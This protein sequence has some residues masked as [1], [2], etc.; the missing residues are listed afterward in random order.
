[1]KKLFI[2]NTASFK[3]E[4]FIPI[5]DPVGMYCCGPTVYNYAHI[6]N[7]RTYIFEDVL[8][9]VLLFLGYKVKHVINITDVGHLT[10]DADIGEDKMEKG[11]SREGKTVWEIAKYYTDAFKQNIK[12]LNILEPDIWP[13]ATDHIED[14]IN[15]IKIL[16]QKGYTYKTGDGIYFDTSK[17]PRYAEFAKL[18]V[19]NLEAGS[20]VDMGEK[21]NVTDFAL[22]KFSPKDKKR[23]M[24]WNSPWGIGF[25]GWHIECSSMSLKYLKQPIDIH[26]G[27]MDHIR[28]HHTNE[29][30][31]AEAATQE[32]FVKYW[33]HGEFLVL[34][35]GKM[36]KSSGNFITL[37]LLKEKGILPLSY[38][39]FCYSAHYRSPLIF[40]FEAVNAAQ[41][42]YINLKKAIKFYTNKP[43]QDNQISNENVEKMLSSFF[44]AVCDDLNLPVAC[45][46]LWS[47]VKNNNFTR[48]EKYIAIQEADKILGLDLLKEEKEESIVKE[49]DRNGLRIRFIL[50]DDI[51][52]KLIENVVS[53]V[54]A[55]YDARRNKNFSEADKIRNKLT[56]LKI[57]IRDLPNSVVECK[58]KTSL[59]KELQEKIK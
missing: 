51:D 44:D 31:Q 22:W 12:E 33:L 19:E 41:T 59:D 1:M 17:F 45:A 25:P 35:K 8:K 36:A 9:R 23:Q 27:G 6:G 56:E 38:R 32:K 57:E 20:R 11:A 42:G 4:E 34:D 5:H 40:S 26:C 37:D 10:S 24:E 28:V 47:L 48:E 46:S 54:W 50:S 49:F 52:E 7:L 30:A 58:I 43:K 53:L 14:M 16:E 55:R 13:R 3:K 18:D 29:I 39:Y 15:T 21:R 2:F